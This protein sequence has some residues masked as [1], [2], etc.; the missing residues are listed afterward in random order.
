MSRVAHLLLCLL[1]A[2]SLACLPAAAAPLSI[3]FETLPGADGVLGTADDV[4]TPST[5][6]SPLSTQYASVGLTFKQ[7]TLFQASFYNGDPTNHFLSS[8]N[9]IGYLS[10]PVFCISIDSNSYWDASLTAYDAADHVIAS[11]T[12]LNPTAGSGFYATTISLT[13]SQ[14]IDHFF[15]RDASN[16]D[17]ILN[18]DNL[19]LNVAASVVPEPSQ[20]A[21][22]AMGLF[23]LSQRYLRNKRS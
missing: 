7:G 23:V 16:F 18:L 20:L 1:A 9:P 19:V 4:P 13:T 12:A 8:T 2:A 6:M 11:I 22:F 3:N 10:V 17:H 14:A 15:I 21:L 5:F